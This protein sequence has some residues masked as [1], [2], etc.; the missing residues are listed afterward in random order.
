ML[1]VPIALYV[2][3]ELTTTLISPLE[4]SKQFS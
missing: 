2:P 3:G 4:V 1:I